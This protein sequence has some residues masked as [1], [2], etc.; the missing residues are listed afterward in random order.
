MSSTSK[1][2]RVIS[3]FAGCGGSSLG[4]KLAGCKVLAA[5]EFDKHA[6]AV[7]RA[8]FQETR[9]YEADIATLDPLE[10]L[11]ELGLEPGELEIL[12]G[13][14]PCQGFSMAGKRRMDDPRNRLFE[15][16]VRLLRAIRPK[17]FVMENV[18]GLVT[19]KMRGIFYEMV[20]ALSEAGYEVR[21][22]IL[23][24]VHYGVPQSRKRVILIGFRKDLDLIP[25]HPVPC[26]HPVTFRQA[27]EDLS[28]H[29]MI[30][31]PK[32]KA[33]HTAKAIRAGESGA[34]LH[35]RYRQKANEFSL[36]RLAWDAPS[37]TVLKTLRPGQ[38]GLLHPSE[39][40][41]LSIGELKR[42]CA[43]PDDFVLHG[44]FIDRWG[45]LGN[46]VPP[47]LTKAVAQSVV[48]QLCES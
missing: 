9:L 4:Y 22:R 8:N 2:M 41:F 24:A 6:A 12:D 7:Y 10:V 20:K 28:E 47:L 27:T 23:N 31:A 37:P 38:V 14:P 25:E 11:K 19:G 42:V 40:R 44:S 45:R 36:I 16:Y 33:L 39:D 15:E 1:S 46:A 3:L 26:T 34:D 30:Q 17:A 29:E 48:R 13:S 35:K 18:P 5:V 43:F 21:G 32:G